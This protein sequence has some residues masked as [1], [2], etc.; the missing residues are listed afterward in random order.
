M[1]QDHFI[2]PPHFLPEPVK[3]WPLEKQAL[4]SFDAPEL[5]HLPILLAQTYVVP[6][7]TANEIGPN[8]ADWPMSPGA[9]CMR[10]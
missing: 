10:P 6:I 2:Q 4:P 9:R 8:M 3:V 1:S 7:A 5:Q